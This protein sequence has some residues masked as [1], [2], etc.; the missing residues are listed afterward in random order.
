MPAIAKRNFSLKPLLIFPF[1]CL[2]G[3]IV[4][5]FVAVYQVSAIEPQMSLS[6]YSYE[7]AVILTM[8]LALH[9][10]CLMFGAVGFFQVVIAAVCRFPAATDSKR[11][12]CK[13][14]AVTFI[15][16]LHGVVYIGYAALHIPV[17]INAFDRRPWFFLMMVLIA[18]G[19]LSII[20]GILVNR[21]RISRRAASEDAR[22]A[23]S[24]P[25]MY[26]GIGLL[27][28]MG[29][30]SMAV[31]TYFSVYLV[32]GGLFSSDITFQM[33]STL[34]ETRGFLYQR[35][36]LW[37]YLW[38]LV[39]AV[40]VALIKP[41]RLRQR[42]GLALIIATGAGL[43]MA[44]GTP[45]FITATF[46]GGEFEL[47]RKGCTNIQQQA[48]LVK[49]QRLSFWIWQEKDPVESFEGLYLKL[50][51]STEEQ[52]PVEEGIFVTVRTDGIW[53][54]NEK[55]C[56]IK[57]GRLAEACLAPFNT[58]RAPKLNYLLKMAGQKAEKKK[59]KQE[60]FVQHRLIVEGMESCPTEKCFD[61]ILEIAADRST[62][63]KTLFSVIQSAQG[64]G[65][66][67]IKLIVRSPSLE[68]L[69][70]SYTGALLS[71]PVCPVY[72]TIDVNWRSQ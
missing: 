33:E 65:F 68:S 70:Q 30:L 43:L 24:S 71:P 72:R 12:F 41:F 28:G 19:I 51:H 26:C 67:G 32:Y 21:F 11:G 64:T 35:L 47:S 14:R 36:W 10:M 4:S 6:D 25:A 69:H 29:A 56:E 34:G 54:E 40:W 1:I 57:N 38:P 15:S 27:G 62:P 13:R 44:A 8:Y 16:V 31:M 60:S 59:Q 45:Y 52:Q 49:K 5:V 17:F 66:M 9:G 58:A 18:L 48:E 53:I 50:P 55:A 3:A 37:V 39:G 46:I 22:E 2:I 7:L 63:V 42:R 61:L 23:P 20:F